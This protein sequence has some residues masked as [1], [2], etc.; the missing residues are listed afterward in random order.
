MSIK[1]PEHRQQIE[2][3]DYAISKNI[4]NNPV[5]SNVEPENESQTQC[6]ALQKDE[7]KIIC[8]DLKEP[9]FFSKDVIFH[10]EEA[11]S[12]SIQDKT[13]PLTEK[14][15]PT[16]DELKVMEFINKV[17][18]E[19][20]KAIFKSFDQSIENARKLMKLY[21]EYVKKVVVPKEII[22]KDEIKKQEKQ[23]IIT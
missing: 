17:K 10:L 6:S 21:N 14:R 8:K 12:P 5:S 3:P 13:K 15:M 1:F 9:P 7:T 19:N 23:K 22:N 18:D 16:E 11:E 2:K 4:N 20:I